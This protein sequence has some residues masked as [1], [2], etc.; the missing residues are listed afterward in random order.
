MKR[1][2]FD[3]YDNSIRERLKKK[4][5]TIEFISNGTFA[6]VWKV[7]H[8]DSLPPSAVKVQRY[9]NREEG[10]PGY[11]LRELDVLSRISH[12]KLIK[13]FN[14]S[15]SH[16]KNVD[17][18]LPLYP[19]DLNHWIST[20]TWTE[21]SKK[22]Q[23]FFYDLLDGLYALH[24]NNVYH[25]DIKTTNI[26]VRGDSLV[27]SDLGL[28]STDN[29]DTFSS[30]S[31]LCSTDYRPPELLVEGEVIKFNRVTEQLMKISDDL[32]KCYTDSFQKRLQIR[33]MSM[34]KID[35]WSTGCVMLT[36]ILG[37]NPFMRGDDDRMTFLAI[38]NEEEEL[39]AQDLEGLNVSWDIISTIHRNV[40]KKTVWK[41]VRRIAP[42]WYPLLRR[43]LSIR[44]EQRVTSMQAFNLFCSLCET[45]YSVSSYTKRS[46]L[47]KDGIINDTRTEYQLMK[48]ICYRAKCENCFSIAKNLFHSYL[49]NNNNRFKISLN[50]I[51]I[52][53]VYIAI[54]YKHY[55]YPS[56][57]SLIRTQSEDILELEPYVLS[58]CKYRIGE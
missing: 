13:L 27:L 31:I 23:G 26:L 14:I 56:L 51:A 8:Y 22:A 33:Q 41:T 9:E 18:E 6:S 25:M 1:K 12:P 44:P 30:G 43:M 19:Q 21:R 48:N 49:L 20:R 29:L 50:Q 11:I 35:V 36:Y 58:A 39:C 32:K 16:G 57:E 52:C 55:S 46:G 17:M 47:P 38:L 45:N 24:S 10:T 28:C 15:Q 53:C 4:F 2:S 40:V 42:K 54:K 7:E 3:M 37:Y 34:E 5:K